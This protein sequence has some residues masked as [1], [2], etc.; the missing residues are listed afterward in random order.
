MRTSY[1]A[2]WMSNKFTLLHIEEFN[3]YSIY[4]CVCSYIVV[5]FFY[6]CYTVFVSILACLLD[7]RRGLILCSWF[8]FRIFPCSVGWQSFSSSL[9][10]AVT[11][12]SHPPTPA[13]TPLNMKAWWRRCSAVS[14]YSSTHI[15]Q[16]LVLVFTC[17][18]WRFS[19]TTWTETTT[20]K[21]FATP[22]GLH[23]LQV[24]SLSRENERDSY[25][26]SWGTE[27]LDNVALSSSPIHSGY[28]CSPWYRLYVL[29]ETLQWKNMWRQ[30]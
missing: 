18:Q 6:V 23:P 22:L 30:T 4:F 19:V 13:T 21:C 5:C 2:S 7:N 15:I 20:T 27:N 3:N 8:T 14:R 11:A 9:L 1:S 29:S 17:T 24:S 26:L 10:P 16:T 12:L 28:V 25:R